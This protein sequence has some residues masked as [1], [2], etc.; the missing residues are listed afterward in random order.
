MFCGA[1]GM[2][3]PDGQNFCPNCGSPLSDSQAQSWQPEQSAQQGG[4]V[5]N[6]SM[7]GQQTNMQQSA[8]QP[9]GQAYQQQP[10][11]QQIGQQPY[12]QPY[13]QGQYGQQGMQQPYPQQGQTVYQGYGVPGADPRYQK[14]GGWLLF[15]VILSI[16]GVV[17]S[18][19]SAASTGMLISQVPRSYHMFFII[20]II[21]T[22]VEAGLN[23]GFIVLVFKRSDIFLKYYQ[24][25]SIVEVVLAVVLSILVGTLPGANQVAGASVGSAIGSIIGG[26]VSLVLFTLY[27]CKSERVRTYMGSDSYLKKALFRI[28]A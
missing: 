25:I 26:V 24:I 21:I 22:L 2:Q 9:Y 27:F 28:G 8:Q 14:L 1:C 23:T 12:Q 17:G 7:Y 3:V 15:F 16:L 18:L 13:Q 5:P 11:Q 19:G 6:Q 4:F 10:Y 20:S